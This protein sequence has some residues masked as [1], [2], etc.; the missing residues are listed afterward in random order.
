ME[1][2]IM[3]DVGCVGSNLNR[4]W[5]QLGAGVFLD[6][7]TTVSCY[8]KPRL[9]A[10]ITDGDAGTVRSVGTSNLFKFNK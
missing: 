10:F 8:R 4:R 9:L 1:T 3:I 2:S 6:T 5:D 7:H